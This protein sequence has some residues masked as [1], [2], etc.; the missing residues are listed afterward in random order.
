[1]RVPWL[2][3]AAGA[4]MP[5][6]VTVLVTGI[7]PCV[8]AGASSTMDPGNT[9]W[10]DRSRGLPGASRSAITAQR[11][12]RGETGRTPGPKILRGQPRA[13]SS[14]AVRTNRSQA[15]EMSQLPDS[16]RSFPPARHA[17]V[18]QRRGRLAQQRRLAKPRDRTPNASGHVLGHRSIA[19]CADTHAPMRAVTARAESIEF[20]YT[21]AIV[22]GPDFCVACDLASLAL[23]Q[24]LTHFSSFFVRD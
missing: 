6:L 3:D 14:P 8:I 20:A 18:I 2:R 5:V 1:M 9:C 24:P 19:R 21:D 7:Q 22:Y 16:P 4:V 23:R 15:A 12:G 11:S 13:G 10:D 17:S